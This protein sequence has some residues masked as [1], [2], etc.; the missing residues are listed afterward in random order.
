MPGCWHC[1]LKT[2]ERV[3]GV[4]VKGRQQLGQKIFTHF[5][6]IKNLHSRKIY[7]NNNHK[8]ITKTET[9]FM[10][11]HVTKAFL[12]PKRP[13]FNVVDFTVMLGLGKFRRRIGSAQAEQWTFSHFHFY[14][15]QCLREYAF[16]RKFGSE[17]RG[18]IAPSH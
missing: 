9:G 14:I 12:F 5:S 1:L 2:L 10:M 18:L 15:L 17:N 8:Q 16:K 3:K 6:K 11:T 7:E 13:R 4:A